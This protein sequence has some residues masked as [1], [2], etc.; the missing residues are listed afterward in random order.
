M[1]RARQDAITT[2]IMEIISGAESLAQ[3]EGGP[4]DLLVDHIG[5]TEYFDKMHRPHAHPHTAGAQ[6]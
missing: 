2:E 3:G 6:S 5:A 4:E 1:N